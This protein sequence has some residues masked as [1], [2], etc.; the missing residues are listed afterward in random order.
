[1]Q[2]CNER[3][4]ERTRTGKSGLTMRMS[5]STSSMFPGTSTSA[6]P[7]YTHSF[8]QWFNMPLAEPEGGAPA[9]P[10]PNG[11][12]SLFNATNAIFSK[13]NCSLEIHFKTNFHRNRAKTL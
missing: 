4:S 10:P 7:N 11:R 2:S 9:P 3:E 1:M 8:I 12:G 5:P 6:E 13:I